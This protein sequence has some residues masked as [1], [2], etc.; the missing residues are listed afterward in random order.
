MEGRTKQKFLNYF[1]IEILKAYN[2]PFTKCVE[3][4]NPIANHQGDLLN[5]KSKW[6]QAKVI[7]TTVTVVQGGAEV[8]SA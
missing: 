6:H 4:G 8:V 7:R 1:S 2:K 3:E 5:S